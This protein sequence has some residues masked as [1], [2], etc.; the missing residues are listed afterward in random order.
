[1]KAKF[2]KESISFERGGDPKGILGIGIH[3]PRIF[4]SR[5]ELADYL[6]I[7]LPDIFGGEIPKDILYKPGGGIIPWYYYNKINNF[8]IKCN[9]TY[10]NWK[11]EKKKNWVELESSEV[12]FW[13]QTLYKKL[14]ELGY[15]FED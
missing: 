13:P 3:S 12:S 8:L 9:H 10:V 2:I 1:M 5:E 4:T 11:G 15:K 6:I 14:A 7:A